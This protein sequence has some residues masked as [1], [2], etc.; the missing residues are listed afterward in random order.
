MRIYKA[1]TKIKTN[2]Y[3]ILPGSILSATYYLERNELFKG[4]IE[5]ITEIH[6]PSLAIKQRRGKPP[7]NLYEDLELIEKRNEEFL[8]EI[9]HLKEVIKKCIMFG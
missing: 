4:K 9:R 1:T 3:D 8:K 7:K 5:F 2:Y 6:L